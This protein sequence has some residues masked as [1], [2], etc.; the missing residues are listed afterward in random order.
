LR[1]YEINK[2][3]VVYQT[4]NQRRYS[5]STMLVCGNDSRD[6]LSESECGKCSYYFFAVSYTMLGNDFGNFFQL[7]RMWCRLWTFL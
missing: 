1:I 5:K 6:T 4:C 7:G 3:I 2:M